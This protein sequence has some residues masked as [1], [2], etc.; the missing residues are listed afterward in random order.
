MMDLTVAQVQ[1]VEIAK[2]LSHDAR[3]II[4]DEPRAPW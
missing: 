2:A 3:V 1:L 4:M